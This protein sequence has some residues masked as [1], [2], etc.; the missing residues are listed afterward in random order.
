MYLKPVGQDVKEGAE[1]YAL[2]PVWTLV[3]SY[4]AFF[5]H[6]SSPK[7]HMT[8][9]MNQEFPG[10]LALSSLPETFVCWLDPVPT[11]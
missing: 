11:V 4:A 7:L 9:F 10:I 5:S 1:H 3:W 2:R 8:N 6:L